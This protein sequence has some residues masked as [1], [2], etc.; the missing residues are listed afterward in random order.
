MT[1]I[2]HYLAR[3]VITHTSLAYTN[4]SMQFEICLK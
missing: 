3:G 1:E 2:I 4:D